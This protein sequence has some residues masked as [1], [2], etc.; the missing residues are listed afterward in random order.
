VITS[1]DRDDRD[2]SAARLGEAR[3]KLVNFIA[4]GAGSCAAVKSLPTRDLLEI[5]ANKDKGTPGVGSALQD[6]ALQVCA[7]KK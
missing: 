4:A 6:L 1:D 2:D 5:Y 7:V 3:Q